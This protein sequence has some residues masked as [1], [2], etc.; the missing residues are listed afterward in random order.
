MLGFIGDTSACRDFCVDQ[1]EYGFAVDEKIAGVDVA[2]PFAPDLCDLDAV[3]FERLG[4]VCVAG[5]APSE[6]EGCRPAPST[7]DPETSVSLG[8][9]CRYFPSPCD[10]VGAIFSGT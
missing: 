2:L 6:R 5:G 7:M 10:F 9:L 1:D 3:L 8:V 4:P